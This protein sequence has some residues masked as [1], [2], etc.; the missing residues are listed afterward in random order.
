M[1]YGSSGRAFGG[2]IFVGRLVNF[3]VSFGVV[4]LMLFEGRQRPRQADL[5]LVGLVLFPYFLGLS[6]QLYT[7]IIATFAELCGVLLSVRGKHAGAA[8]AFVTAIASRQYTVA[9]PIAIVA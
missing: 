5:A 3:V 8:L 4:S 6:V 2:G 9:F 1:W 7:D